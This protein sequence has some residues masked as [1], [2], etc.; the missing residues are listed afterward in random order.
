MHGAECS[1]EDDVTACQPMVRALHLPVT[2]TL[3][4]AT[5]RLFV[6]VT[7]LLASLFELAG[8]SV[9]LATVILERLT[10]RLRSPVAAPA[11][12]VVPMALAPT[13]LVPP[14]VVAPAVKAP[15]EIPRVSR[16]TI[17]MSGDERLTSALLSLKFPSAKV[18]AFAASVNGREAPLEVLVKEGIV[19]LSSPV[20]LS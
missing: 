7:G 4:R 19:A 8:A 5:V 11:P 20:V 6:A 2:M 13:V 14:V 10:N 15:A 3:K 12:A 16:A 1:T 9:L 18:R 17:A